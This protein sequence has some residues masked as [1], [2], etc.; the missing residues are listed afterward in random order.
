VRLLAH[1]DGLSFEQG[2][3]EPLVNLP[4]SVWEIQGGLTVAVR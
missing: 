4:G 2:F 1:G 3:S